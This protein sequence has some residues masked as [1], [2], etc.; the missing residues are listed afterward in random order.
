MTE[1]DDLELYEVTPGNGL[2]LAKQKPGI[3]SLLTR[4]GQEL[5]K[6][7]TRRAWL[8]RGGTPSLPHYPCLDKPITNYLEE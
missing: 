5:S 1:I 4:A 6:E 2:P 7:A 3:Q 8:R